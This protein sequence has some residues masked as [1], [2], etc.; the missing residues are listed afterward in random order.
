[1]ALAVLLRAARFNDPRIAAATAAL[2]GSALPVVVASACAPSGPP[3]RANWLPPAQ[4]ASQQAAAG[5]AASSTRAPWLPLDEYRAQQQQ[6]R[7]ALRGQEVPGLAQGNHPDLFLFVAASGRQYDTR[8]PAPGPCG[9]ALC[10]PDARHWGFQC[11]N[12][13][14]RVRVCVARP[15]VG[16]CQGPAVGQ[17][18][19]PHRLH[20][21][22]DLLCKHL[23]G[24]LRGEGCR[25][26]GRRCWCRCRCCCGCCWCECCCGGRLFFFPGGVPPSR[27]AGWYR[28]TLATI[29][30][31]NTEV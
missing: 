25:G 16:A 11:P 21:Q 6:K 3:S 31:G 28:G 10:P 7:Q 1:M 12:G 20:E 8:L 24:G 2:Q 14:A 23:Y 15:R 29:N 13:S 5:A 26:A 19:L 30:I 18:T 22:T 27:E 17:S 9:N 4:Y